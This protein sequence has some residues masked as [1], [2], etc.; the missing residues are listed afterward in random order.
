MSAGEGRR[1]T[2]VGQG[3]TKSGGEVPDTGRQGIKV[4]EECRGG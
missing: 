3:R 1:H 4:A 2:R